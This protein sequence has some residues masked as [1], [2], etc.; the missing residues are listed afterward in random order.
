MKKFFSILCN[1]Y[2]PVGFGRFANKK[3]K[4]GEK[5]VR[6]FQEGKYVFFKLIPIILL[7][8]NTLENKEPF[9]NWLNAF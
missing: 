8:L 2:L 4:R 3:K 9:I 1:I 6:R 7:V 5:N